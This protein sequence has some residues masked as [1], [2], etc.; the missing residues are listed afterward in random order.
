M[1]GAN[2][3]DVR[4]VPTA[5]VRAAGRL[6]VEGKELAQK[7]GAIRVS[8]I[9]APIDGNPGPSYPGTV[10]ADGTFEFRAWPLPSRIRVF[11]ADRE[12]QVKAVRQNGRDLQ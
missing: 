6:I 12:Y 11:I 1:N 3:N 9:P 4:V 2:V 5:P 10:K 8:A 7:T